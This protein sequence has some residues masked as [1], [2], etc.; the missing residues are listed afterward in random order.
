MTQQIW[1]LDRD[2]E[3]LPFC[4]QT[5]GKNGSTRLH[6]WLNHYEFTNCRWDFVCNHNTYKHFPA[7]V[8]IQNPIDKF[9]KGFSE[10]ISNLRP[11]YA[12]GAIHGLPP[13]I[14][15]SPATEHIIFKEILSKM[16]IDAIDAFLFQFLVRIDMYMYDYH[17]KLQ[18]GVLAQ[19]SAFNLKYEVLKIDDID[20]FHTIVKQKHA[21]HFAERVDG[22]STGLKSIDPERV[23]D[24]DRQLIEE[25]LHKIVYE[26]IDGELSDIRQ[27]LKP[28]LGLW[29]IFNS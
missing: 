9:I 15:A 16:P 19:L 17:L 10:I 14:T 3:A 23:E 4:V 7:Y 29:E 18:T 28:D 6:K 24:N 5:I 21:K 20:N 13:Q 1:V 11:A 25:R 2:D 26:H 8:F 12:V 22:L 27:Y